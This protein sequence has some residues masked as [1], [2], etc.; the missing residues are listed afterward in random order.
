MV[1]FELPADMSEE[2]IA[3]IPHQRLKVNELMEQGRIASYALSSDRQ[4]LWCV[5]KADTEYDVME[6]IAQF[7]LI[8][9]MKPSINELLF[10]NVVSMRIPLFSLN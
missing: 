7:P 8:D 9:F 6:T 5:V 10:N 1:E 3:K 2:F 4:R